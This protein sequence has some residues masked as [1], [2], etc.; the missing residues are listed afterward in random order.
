MSH[1]RYAK[2]ETGTYRWFDLTP[3]N[4]AEAKSAFV[5]QDSFKPGMRLRHPVTGELVDSHTRWNQINKAENLTCVG[6]DLLSKRPGTGP[7]KITEEVILDRISKA[8][9]ICSDPAKR[10]AYDNM[11]MELAERNARLLR[12]A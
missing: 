3:T 11:N 5:H 8:E 2:D 9:S 1:S 12:G 6:N 7:E 4:T 10:R